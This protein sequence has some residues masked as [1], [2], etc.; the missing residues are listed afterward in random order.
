MMRPTLLNRPIAAGLF[1]IGL[2]LPTYSLALDCEYT[3]NN[4]WGSGF[5][6]TISLTN[7]TAETVTGWEVA[8]TFNNGTNLSHI[9]N[10][11]QLAESPYRAANVEWN[12][13]L[14]PGS[15][16]SFGF[17]GVGDNAN[18]V[19]TYCG[20]SGEDSSDDDGSG[21]DGADDGQSGDTLSS[22]ELTQQM[23]VGWNAGNSLEA[24]GGETAWGNPLLMPE[25]FQAVKAAGF[26]SVRLPVA[27]SQFADAE[28]FV[29][30]DS[31]LSRVEEVVNYALDA[32][33]YVMMNLHWDGGW[34]QPT[35][36]QEAYVNNRL[37]IMWTQIADRF[38]D[39]DDRLLFAGSNEVMVEGDYGTPTYEYYTVQNGF[40]QTFVD[41]VRATGGNNDDR[42]LVVQGFNTNIDHAVNY[43]QVPADSADDRLLMEVHYYDPY[44]F[45]LNG[46]SNITQWGAI[47]TDLSKTESWANETHVDAQFQKMASRFVEEGVGV[48]L[49]EYGVISRPSLSDHETY[50]V[51]WNRYVTESAMAHG[52]V[53]M[54]WDNGYAGEHGMAIFDRHTA[55]PL[56]P[57]II[58]A[59]TGSVE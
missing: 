47:A 29:I 52:L 6:A 18:G 50:R 4:D 37:Q 3:V 7:D 44:N 15:S 22:V 53:P 54:Y 9:W 8:W 43:A 58:N 46:D 30:K 35:Y 38:K 41:T 51:Y 33:L 13:M 17:Q 26:D 20:T 40:N 49:G 23:G 56:Y 32:D 34:M 21:D 45:T 59:I 19:I 31:W 10:A 55:A 11:E 2:F 16:A 28:N 25:L 14:L 39:Y 24:I 5:T 12:A 42:F 1:I 48:I 57:E 27:W 36:D